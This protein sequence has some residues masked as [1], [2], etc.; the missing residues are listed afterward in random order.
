[1]KTSFFGCFRSGVMLC[2]GILVFSLLDSPE[3]NLIYGIMFMGWI[4][5]DVLLTL[6]IVCSRKLFLIKF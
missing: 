6:T 1:M 5:Q 2:N 4:G 3:L